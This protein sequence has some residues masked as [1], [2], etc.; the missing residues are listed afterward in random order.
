MNSNNVIEFKKV[1]KPEPVV[2]ADYFGSEKIP[3][4][5]LLSLLD[6][7]KNNKSENRE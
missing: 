7:L 2:D 4:H 6:M 1:E 3:V 5:D